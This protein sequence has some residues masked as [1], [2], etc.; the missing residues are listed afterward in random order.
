MGA[1]EVASCAGG[2][3]QGFGGF[4]RLLPGVHGL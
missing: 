1:A 2:G 3:L 4:H